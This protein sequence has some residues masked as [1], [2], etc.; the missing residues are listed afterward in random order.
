MARYLISLSLSIFAYRIGTIILFQ[1]LHKIMHVN[2][3]PWLGVSTQKWYLQEH[4]VEGLMLP[5]SYFSN[6]GVN[7]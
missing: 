1:G 3:F 2:D 5:L 4:E 6:R 7:I